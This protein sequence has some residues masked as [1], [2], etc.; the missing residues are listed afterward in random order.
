M[1]YIHT[2]AYTCIHCMCSVVCIHTY[3]NLYR[4]DYSS[5]GL[6]GRHDIHIHIRIHTRHHGVVCSVYV[7]IPTCM[8]MYIHTFIHGIVLD[9]GS[10]VGH[11]FFQ[12]LYVY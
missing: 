4:K 6:K 3:I 2:H 5:L 10:R 1:I 12:D 11:T 9:R 7:C 8:H